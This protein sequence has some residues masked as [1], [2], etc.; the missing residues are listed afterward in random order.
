MTNKSDLWLAFATNSLTLQSLGNVKLCPLKFV[1]FCPKAALV[2]IWPPQQHCLQ[3][4]VHAQT[5][6]GAEGLL[7]VET[8]LEQPIPQI[9]M[10]CHAQKVVICSFFSGVLH[11]QRGCRFLGKE[12]PVMVLQA[13]L[14]GKECILLEY[15]SI[16]IDMY[17]KLVSWFLI[18]DLISVSLQSQL[19]SSC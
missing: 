14:E 6:G 12:E 1:L 13:A 10:E 5:G 19:F 18:W 17:S 11:K 2:P 16:E 7:H 4:S 3:L 8:A 15:F 9:W